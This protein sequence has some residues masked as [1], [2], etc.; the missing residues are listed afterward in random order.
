MV[1]HLFES[2]NEGGR[3]KYSFFCDLVAHVHAF[4]RSGGIPSY[5]KSDSLEPRQTKGDSP[6]PDRSRSTSPIIVIGDRSLPVS[7]C[8][9]FRK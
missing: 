6:I 5:R 8:H 4:N 2:I 9:S 7:L 1:S 3:E